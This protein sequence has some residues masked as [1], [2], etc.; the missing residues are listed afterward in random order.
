MHEIR[1][2]VPPEHAKEAA[3]LAHNIGI[4]RVSI[5][6]VYIDGPDVRRQVVS[7]ETSTPR[8]RLFI[9]ALL[10][11]SAGSVATISVLI[12]RHSRSP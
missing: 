10:T 6:D 8:A 2:T 9:E 7:V 1:A 3:R 4:E 5:A 11:S 12:C